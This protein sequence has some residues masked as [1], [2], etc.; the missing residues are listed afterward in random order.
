MILNQLWLPDSSGLNRWANKCISRWA[1]F[2]SRRQFWQGDVYFDEGSSNAAIRTTEPNSISFR[3]LIRGSTSATQV[4][5]VIGTC[6]RKKLWCVGVAG[7]YHHCMCWSSWIWG[8]LRF[9]L[10]HTQN[11]TSL[12]EN[13]SSSQKV[14]RLSSHHPLAQRWFQ[15]Q[16][17]SVQFLGPCAKVEVLLR[18]GVP[19]THPPTILPRH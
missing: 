8:P 4:W 12:V 6:S 2:G 14:Y 15:L 10:S 17:C 5:R 18:A 13:R 7:T 3:N 16:R 9:C 1:S 19:E 11:S